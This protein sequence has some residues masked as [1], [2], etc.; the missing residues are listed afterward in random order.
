VTDLRGRRVVVTG[1]A[2]GIGAAMARRFVAGGAT[3]VINDLDADALNRLAAETGALPVPGDAAD[4][5]EVAALVA[6]SRQHLVEIDLFC[7]NAGIGTAGD[8]D[9]P[10]QDWQRAWQVNVMSHV[11]A[12]RHL[13]PAW[14]QRGAGR[15]LTTV[16]A[17]G[18]LTMPGS[19]PY[20]V[21]KHA[22]LS[23][24]EWLSITYADRGITV[25]ALCPQGVRTP[26]LENSGPL[27]HAVLD[28]AAISPEQVA[29]DVVAALD[30]RRFLVLPHPEVAGYYAHRA[31]DP[32]AW[33]AGMRKL[34]ARATQAP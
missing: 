25:Q 3:V 34:V 30:H 27:G 7:A 11:Y 18:L 19:A 4:D 17:A 16:S 1:A 8:P 10:D 21:T 5:R 22:A 24:A 2:S 31:S 12:A 15:L 9:T 23:F 14:L 33:L 20:S 13:L 26:L 28:A 29:E 32:D 6:Q